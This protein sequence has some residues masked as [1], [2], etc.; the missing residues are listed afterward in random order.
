MPLGKGLGAL[1]GSSAGRKI[2]IAPPQIH[3]AEA[4]AKIWQ[5]PLTT[6]AANPR[7][8]RREFNEAGLRELA[9]SV[10]AHGIL[11]PLLVAEK[12]D[13]GY[14]LIAGERRLRAARLCGLTTA[15]VIV[16]TVA[17]REKLELSLIE[18]IQRADL[19]ALEEAFAYQ[20][21]IEEFGL[22]QEAVAARVG[23]SRPAI[24]NTVRLLDLPPEAQAALQNKKI[25]PAQA[26]TLLSLPGR[27]A[28]L[29]MLATLTR[30]PLTV[31]ELEGMVRDQQGRAARRRRDANLIHLEHELAAQLGTKVTITQK[32]G[33]GTIAIVYYSSEELR[34]IVEKIVPRL[35]A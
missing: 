35:R 18:N 11:Q 7:Q 34:A 29:E 2:A 4:S 23:K 9:A 10:A 33:R 25:N 15:P 3:G 6:I 30:A 17:D 28:Q 22:T 1:I 20:R 26:R 27:A 13:G 12:A 24:A 31:R 8:P 21:L 32:A 19:T 16:K 14:E 5:V